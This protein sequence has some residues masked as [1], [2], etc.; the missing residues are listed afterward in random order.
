VPLSEFH[1][2]ISEPH[3]WIRS[4]ACACSDPPAAK[5]AFVLEFRCLLISRNPATPL[6]LL[7]DQD[8]C[9]PNK[10][11]STEPLQQAQGDWNR[12]TNLNQLDDGIGQHGN[13]MH[14]TTLRAKNQMIDNGSVYVLAQA[15]IWAGPD[16]WLRAATTASLS[17]TSSVSIPMECAM[18]IPI[19]SS[20]GKRLRSVST[21]QA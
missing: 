18:T 11:W 13:L 17:R 10:S 21:I 7:P 6:G 3:P 20:C 5:C 15:Q 19:R 8:K 14:Q 1:N 9:P 4:C 2:S 16:T 12:C